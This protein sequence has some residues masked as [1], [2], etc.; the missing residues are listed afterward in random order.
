MASVI[1]TLHVNDTNLMAFTTPLHAMLANHMLE[2]L[3][4][5]ARIVRKGC[6]RR[7]GVTGIEVHAGASFPQVRIS[8][9]DRASKERDKLPSSLSSLSRCWTPSLAAF[10]RACHWL[11]IDPISSQFGPL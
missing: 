6:P 7:P 11:S 4:A 8:E 2:T 9:R 1:I 3:A 5:W 10:C